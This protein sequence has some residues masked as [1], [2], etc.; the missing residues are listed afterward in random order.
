MTVQLI[1]LKK[2][3]FRPFCSTILTTNN[4]QYFQTI[5]IPFYKVGAPCQ[6][7]NLVQRCCFEERQSYIVSQRVIFKYGPILTNKYDPVS[8]PERKSILSKFSGIIFKHGSKAD[9]RFLF[10]LF[11]VG[12]ILHLIT[13]IQQGSK[14]KLTEPKVTLQK[15]LPLHW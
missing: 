6:Q 2:N 5:P 4:L 7:R 3:I 12:T 9:N 15:F 8:F 11:E 14:S 1:C 10:I 13:I